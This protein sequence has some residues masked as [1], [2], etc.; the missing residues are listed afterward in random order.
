MASNITPKEHVL[1]RIANGM[2]WKKAVGHGREKWCVGEKILHIRYR[3]KPVS[4]GGSTYSYNIN[5]NTL[6]SDFE[7]WICGNTGIYY[8]IPIQ[9]VEFI[10]NHPDAYVDYTHPERR[11]ADVNID[12]DRCRYARGGQTMDFSSYRCATL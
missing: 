1:R 9:V 5:P 4:G 12:N 7:V 10:Y 6:A 2:S 3:S 11:V 8:L